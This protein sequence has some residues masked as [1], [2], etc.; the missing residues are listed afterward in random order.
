M[1]T[2]ITECDVCLK[3]EKGYEILQTYYSLVLKEINTKGEKPYNVAHICASCFKSNDFLKKLVDRL[4][5]IQ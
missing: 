3:S 5:T 1:Y 4:K 2:T